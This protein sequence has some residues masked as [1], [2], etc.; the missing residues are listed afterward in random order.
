[1]AV[2]RAQDRPPE[3][4]TEGSVGATDRFQLRQK[5]LGAMN[6]FW[7]KAIP[8]LPMGTPVEPPFTDAGGGEPGGVG[9]SYYF[10]VTCWP[11]PYRTETGRRFVV[12]K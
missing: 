9:Q 2:G 8:G 3:H 10:R 6:R 4:Y 11:A 5:G 7:M 1:M 12:A